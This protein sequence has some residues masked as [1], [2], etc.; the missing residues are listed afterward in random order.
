MTTTKRIPIPLDA[1]RALWLVAVTT[2]VGLLAGCSDS[3]ATGAPAATTSSPVA[4]QTA[5]PTPNL[6]AGVTSTSVVA[7]VGPAG[8]IR[9]ETYALAFHPANLTVAAGTFAIFLVNPSDLS[10][11]PHGLAIGKRVI[12]DAIVSSHDVKLGDSAAF[13][14]FGLPAGDYVI[15]CTIPSHWAAGMVGTLTVR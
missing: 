9:T 14:V 5:S 6:W 11:G 12:G 15:W 8:S 3:R 13:T 10:G 2:L 4:V 1:R 7:D